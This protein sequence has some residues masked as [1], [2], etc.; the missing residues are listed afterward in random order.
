M[1]GA[2]MFQLITAHIL[3][4]MTHPITHTHHVI[5]WCHGPG[6]H[7]FLFHNPLRYVCI[8]L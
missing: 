2:A 1:K 6:E 7:A 8:S 4:T 3:T 5:L